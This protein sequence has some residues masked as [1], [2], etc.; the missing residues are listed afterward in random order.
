MKNKGN[1]SVKNNTAPE[2][3]NSNSKHFRQTLIPSF[4][5]SLN[6]FS[7]IPVTMF[8]TSWCSSR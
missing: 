7:T 4:E 5:S 1:P 8:E 3:E 6:H 2:I